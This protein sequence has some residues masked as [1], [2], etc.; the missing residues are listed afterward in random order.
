MQ[1]SIP[2]TTLITKPFT[3]VVR[4]TVPDNVHQQAKNFCVGVTEFKSRPE[5]W[6]LYLRFL[7]TFL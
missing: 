5:C 7:V 6:L 4:H 1:V 2:S 3:H